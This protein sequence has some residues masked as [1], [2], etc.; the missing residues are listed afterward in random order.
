M[1]R[2]MLVITL[3]G[4]SI[5]SDLDGNEGEYKQRL[6]DQSNYEPTLYI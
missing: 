4:Y 2:S 6:L 5:C 1:E 3:K